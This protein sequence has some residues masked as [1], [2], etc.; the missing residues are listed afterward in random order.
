MGNR[1]LLGAVSEANAKKKRKESSIKQL[2]AE[3][4][5]G[6]VFFGPPEVQRYNELNQQME[7]EKEQE[8]QD[9]LYPRQ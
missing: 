8:S 4:G 5:S 2:R 3:D 6:A 1:R 7:S 9:K